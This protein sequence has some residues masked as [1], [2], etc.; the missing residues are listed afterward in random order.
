MFPTFKPHSCLVWVL[1]RSAVSSMPASGPPCLHSC[2]LQ[3]TFEDDLEQSFQKRANYV[4]PPTQ[5]KTQ[6]TKQNMFLRLR[7]TPPCWPVSTAV[8]LQHTSM[9]LAPGT[10]H[11]PWTLK[12]HVHC[13]RAYIPQHTPST[14]LRAQLKCPPHPSISAINLPTPA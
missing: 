12:D 8:R 1:S 2:L 4:I 7:P 13:P 9:N 6:H 14:G 5:H 11:L 3:S 10:G